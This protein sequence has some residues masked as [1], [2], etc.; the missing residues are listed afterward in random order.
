M[1]IDIVFAGL[2]LNI[3]IEKKTPER[4]T[5]Y[6]WCLWKQGTINDFI[7]ETWMLFAPPYQHFWLR[8]CADPTWT[9]TAPRKWIQFTWKQNGSNHESHLGTDK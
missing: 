4:C 5:F 9:K 8:A 1:K 6:G 3:V 2:N 7:V